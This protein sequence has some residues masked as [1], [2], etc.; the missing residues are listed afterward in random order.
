MKIS[1]QFHKAS[2]ITDKRKPFGLIV[3]ML[4][5]FSV[6][7]VYSITTL[8]KISSIDA[9]GHPNFLS[10]HAAPLAIN[11]DKLFVVN[12]PADSFDVIE[13]LSLTVVKRI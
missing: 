5:A 11:G 6:S 8:G 4:L 2:S 10:P 12:T 7:M 3:L 9:V 13:M 1:R